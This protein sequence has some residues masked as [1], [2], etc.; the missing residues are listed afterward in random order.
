MKIY[1]CFP[2]FDENLL[3]ECRL[4]IL[5]QFVDK[6]IIVESIYSHSGNKKKLN[7]NINNFKDFK[8]KIEYIEVKELPDNLDEKDNVEDDNKRNEIIIKNAI[9]RENY[10]RNK[11]TEGLSLANKDDVILIGDLDEIPLLNNKVFENID[12]KVLIFKQ[13]MFYYKFNLINKNHLWFGTK[14][15]KKKN[16]LSPVW[17]RNLKSKKYSFW[18]FDIHFSKKKYKNI[19]FVDNGGWH[20][21]SLKSASDIEKKMKNFAHHLEYENS[22]INLEKIK[23]LILEK[24]ISYDHNADKTDTN[25]WN[26]E[27]SLDVV[28]DDILPE[29]LIKNKKN[30]QEWFD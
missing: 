26:K 1:D 12:N 11:L 14:A 18:R 30:F 29:Y 8:N 21:T 13:Q 20:F 9:K 23:K 19:F 6:F 7:F 10:Q 2:Y 15:C 16:L 25:K 4:N 27:I 22:G 24:K 5:N 17:L 28:P 3:L